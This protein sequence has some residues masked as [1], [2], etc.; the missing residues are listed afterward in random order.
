MIVKH[1]N[2]R[3]PLSLLGVDSYED[4]QKIDWSSLSASDLTKSRLTSAQDIALFLN[5]VYIPKDPK[6]KVAVN[7]YQLSLMDKDDV[8]CPIRLQYLPSHH[9]EEQMDFTLLDELG[10]EHDTIPGTSIVHR[11]PQRVLF[12]VSNQCQAYCRFCTRK[13]MVGVP[14]EMVHMDE[15]EASI[16]YIANNT[17]IQDVLLSGGDPLMFRDE[18][19][20]YILSQIRKRAPHVMFL[21]IGSRMVVQNP[22]RITKDLCDVLERN[23]VN[24]LNIHI[25]HPKEITPLLKEKCRLLSKS[26]MLGCQTVCLKGINDK[27]EIL[28]DLFMKCLSMKVRPYYVYSTDM[29]E[30]AHQ[31]IVSYKRMLELYEGLR[32]WIS[33]PAIPT[34]VVDGLGGL[35]KMPIIPTYVTQE[36][37]TVKCRNFENKTVEM[38]ALYEPV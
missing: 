15:I 20:D 21:R 28:R 2:N 23:D 29:V 9:E 11:Y 16:N 1:T 32:G 36:D 5:N 30:G 10:E 14:S 34:F 35:G 19:L 24:M 37:G 25:N 7:P 3:T 8:N 26:V 6:F 18:K 38:P 4:L 31:F 13:R 27:V 12:L 33:G 22:L 17:S